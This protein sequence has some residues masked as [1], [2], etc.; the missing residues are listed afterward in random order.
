MISFHRYPIDSVVKHHTYTSSIC[1]TAVRS[2]QGEDSRI[3]SNSR[4]GW[5]PR[6]ECISNA[7]VLPACFNRESSNLVVLQMN[8]HLFGI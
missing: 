7:V 5:M 8:L 4:P 2:A 1:L 6:L 3:A